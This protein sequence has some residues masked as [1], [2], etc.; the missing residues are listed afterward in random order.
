MLDQ[1]TVIDRLS[2][3][4]YIFTNS[5]TE[6]NKPTPLS[7]S[8]L[9]L[10]HDAVELLMH[11]IVERY[12]LGNHNSNK[13][14]T[15]DKYWNVINDSDL[16]PELGSKTSLLRMNN[17]RVAFKHHGTM[18]SKIDL[19]SFHSMVNSFM[20]KTIKDFFDMNLSEISLIQLVHNDE[21]KTHLLKADRHI[22]NNEY[23][24]SL[25]DSKIAFHYMI[26]NYESNKLTNRYNSIFSIFDSFDF[27]TSFNR[28]FNRISF[29][30]KNYN[31]Y[32][33][34]ENFIDSTTRTFTK[35][36]NII[37]IIGYGIDYRMYSW[38]NAITPRLAT[39]INGTIHIDETFDIEKLTEEHADFGINFCIESYLKLINFDIHINTRDELDEE[40]KMRYQ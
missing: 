22:K 9:L 33:E 10:M 30:D 7:Y 32:R 38:F 17:A 21:V 20:N 2:M 39:S 5:T 12:D 15:F 29:G 25:T 35:M 19:I 28:G 11:L 3:I 27:R 34:L 4:K 16:V 24:K 14:L 23:K 6:L 1:K 13:N 18:P 37:K 31:D 26:K 8:S 40:N 36:E